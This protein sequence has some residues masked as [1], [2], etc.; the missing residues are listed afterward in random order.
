MNEA[1]AFE[2]LA[3]RNVNFHDTSGRVHPISGF[4]G[5]GY[6][7]K[8]LFCELFSFCGGFSAEKLPSDAPRPWDMKN[9]E[10]FD[11]KS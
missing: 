8:V 2:D 4:F 5:D 3:L 7:L 10:I 11:E 9:N 1:A 6:R